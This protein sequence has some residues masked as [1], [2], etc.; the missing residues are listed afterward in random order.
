MILKIV[1]FGN[2]KCSGPQVKDSLSSYEMSLD[3]TY[4]LC[5]FHYPDSSLT[6]VS[7]F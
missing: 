1:Y 6:N 7:I 2:E 4:F 5:L 3:S